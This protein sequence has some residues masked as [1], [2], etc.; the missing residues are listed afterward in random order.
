MTARM[1]GIRIT[2]IGGPTVL[3]EVGGWR[4]LTD[5]TFDPP[6]RKYNFGWGTSSRKLAGPAIAA[7]DARPRST[8]SCSA[9]TTTTTTST[10]PGGRCCRRPGPWSPPC[11]GRSGSAATPAGSR[12]GRPTHAGGAGRGRRSR[13]PRRPC[14]HG[15]PLS[16]PIVG[17]VDRLRPAL[18]GPGAR[19]ALDLRR[20][21]PLRRRPRGR[22]PARGRHRDG[23]PRRRPVPGHRPAALHD[24]R[25]PKRSSSAA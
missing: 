19:R 1:E 18:G 14:R 4:L 6:G 9:T 5:P 12:P 15:P 10:T 13:S 23:P 8:R 3:I 21:R 2:H 22:R 24:D 7:G 11:P 20:H 25:A 16:H 17:D